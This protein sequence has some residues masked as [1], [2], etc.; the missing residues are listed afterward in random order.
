MLKLFKRL[1]PQ[2]LFVGLVSVTYITL[3]VVTNQLQDP[4]WADESSFYATS[5]QFSQQLIP[6]FDQLKN[7][8]ELNTP[9]PFIIYGQIQYLFNNGV[10]PGRLLNY[11]LSIT[12]IFLIG[13]PK[14]DKYRFLSILASIGFLLYPYFL[15]FS[16]RYYTDIIAAFFALLGIVSYR[17]KLPIFSCFNFILAIAS[18]Q[19]M[20]AFPLGVAGYELILAIREKKCP[21]LSFFLPAI[22]A[23]SILGWF[24]IFGGLAP[25]KAIE[26]H[27]PAVQLS[28]WS[29]TPSSGFYALACIGLYYVIPEWLLFKRTLNLKSNLTPA[30]IL[31][32]AIL[33][34]LCIAFPPYLVGKGVLWKISELS[35]MQWLKPIIFYGLLLITCWRFARFDLSFCLI[36]CHTF[37]MMK[38]YPW[39]KY[40]LPILM[41]LWFLKAH[42]DSSRVHNV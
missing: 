39:D 12:I 13:W 6:S 21:S 4:L 27:A 40:A 22:A 28:L 25:S 18:R 38:A 19:Y 24:L 8:D 16:T 20:L 17:Q 42:S 29:L 5:Q 3:F 35:F 33:L 11:I 36:L 2:Y 10:F 26:A 15:W 23:L 30:K 14:N 41:V 34:A 1:K 37:I 32:A 7:Y 9:L 31:I